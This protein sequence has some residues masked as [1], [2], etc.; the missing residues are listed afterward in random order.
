MCLWCCWKDLDEQDLMEFIWRF[1]FRMWEVLIFKWF[2]SLKIQIYIFKNQV[3]EGKFSWGRGNTWANGTGHTSKYS[4]SIEM[5]IWGRFF[6]RTYMFCHIWTS[7][8]LA[9][10]IYLGISN[11]HIETMLASYWENVDYRDGSKAVI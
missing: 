3:L 7:Y 1:G 2:L 10:D 5:D 4:N 11:I 9:W 8:E 6:I